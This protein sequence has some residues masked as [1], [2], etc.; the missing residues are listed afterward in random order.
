LGENEKGERNIGNCTEKKVLKRKNKTTVHPKWGYTAKG[1]VR[2]IS[3]LPP[4][5]NRE[6]EIFGRGRVVTGKIWFINKNIFLAPPIF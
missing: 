5:G 3:T 6:K 1:C 4:R 2:S